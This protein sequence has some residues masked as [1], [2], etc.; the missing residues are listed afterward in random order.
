MDLGPNWGLAHLTYG[1]NY[2]TEPRDLARAEEHILLGQKL[3]PDKAVTYDLLG[4]LRRAQGRLEEAA[5]AYTRQ[6]EL[7]P[8]EGSGLKI[9]RPLPPPGPKEIR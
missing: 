2:V 3:W 9:F 1:T 4:D 5:A 8:K 6:I 7:S